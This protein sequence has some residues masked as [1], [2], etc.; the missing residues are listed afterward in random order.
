[1]IR[2]NKKSKQIIRELMACKVEGIC[3]RDKL[4]TEWLRGRMETND[5]FRSTVVEIVRE[6]AELPPCPPI[7]P[8]PEPDP[9]C[10][11]DPCCIEGEAAEVKAEVVDEIL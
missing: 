3:A 11:P 6:E 8:Q 2:A 4:V 7:C 9:I 1:M 10:E 5:A